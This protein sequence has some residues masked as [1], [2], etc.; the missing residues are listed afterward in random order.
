MDKKDAIAALP[1]DQI[2]GLSQKLVDALDKRDTNAYVSLAKIGLWAVTAVL[3]T[4]TIVAAIRQELGVVVQAVQALAFVAITVLG[5]HG[6]KGGQI[7]H[8][9]RHLKGDD[10]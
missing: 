6:Y 10:E 9:L 8:V 1:L 4:V 3:I 2:V 5:Y 7:L